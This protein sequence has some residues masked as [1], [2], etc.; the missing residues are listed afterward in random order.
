MQKSKLGVSVGLLGAALYFLGAISILP[1]FLLAGY[2]LIAEDNEWLKKA[3][4]KMVIIVITFNVLIIAVGLFQNVFSSLNIV[5]G[6]F[7]FIH[8]N[9][10]VPLNL[11][12]L[13]LIILSFMKNLLLVVMGLSA[14]SMGTVKL[15]V[16]DNILNKHL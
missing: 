14:L 13:I 11:D 16:F 10:T 5:L 4:V 6:W 3:A 8:A 2:V 12:S 9:I 15:K 1:A 7:K